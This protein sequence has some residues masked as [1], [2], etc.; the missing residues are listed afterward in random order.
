[1]SNSS[2]DTDPEYNDPILE[3]QGGRKRKIINKKKEK[4]KKRNILNSMYELTCNHIEKS[5]PTVCRVAELKEEDITEFK[6]N[7]CQI[8]DKVEQD[9]Y[10]LTFITVA[11][12]KRIDRKK[13]NR[14]P[15]IVANYFIPVIM[16]NMLKVCADSFSSITSIS[17]RR[18]NIINKKFMLTHSSP[19]EKRG[20]Y[21][22]NIIQ[23]EISHSIEEHIK[24]IKCRKSHHTRRDSGRSYLHPDLSITYMWTQ[25]KKKRIDNNKPI[26]SLSKYQTIFRSKFN[27]N[28]GH[29]RQDT[30]SYCSEQK[31][32][33]QLELDQDLKN[34]LKLQLTIHKRRAKK[35][36]ELL[37]EQS[38][39]SINCSFDMMQTQPIPKLS[40]TEVFYSRQVWI[41]NLTFVI[42]DINQG[43]DNCILYTWNETDSG[44]GPNEVCSALVNF[45]DL[46]ENKLKNESLPPTILNLFS[47]SCSGQNKN[48]FTMATLLFYINCKATIFTKINHIFPVRG[49]SYMPPDR[50]FGRIEQ[51]L[52]KKENIV[53]PKQYIDIFKQF[54][55]VKEYNKDFFIYNYKN[56]VKKIVKTKSQFKSTE[57]KIY[58]YIKGEETVGI[59]K[60]YG[61]LPEQVEVL[62]RK[63]KID[64]MFDLQ[65]LAQTNN[66]K[67]PKQADVKNLLKFFQI[68]DDAKQFYED[69]FKNTTDESII[70]EVPV[71][72][73]DDD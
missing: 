18:L 61:G 43:P 31:L 13:T 14:P 6:N 62:K 4:K 25:W 28:F 21:R 37:R 65:E 63:S 34:E 15:R 69:I 66:V 39:N 70:I 32:K 9:K 54:C 33:I 26:A 10:L 46:L 60:T 56:A 64:S 52:R 20:G 55:T 45:L 16:G 24:G 5:R 73:E 8:T 22:P 47:D 7:L 44:R 27:L 3:V 19:V 40:V 11:K 41:Y 29:P 72:D 68:P 51:V 57:Q 67:L 53:S 59:S 30:C 35:F 17:R 23:E 50:V 36:F 38:S 1:M 71:Y 48:Q 2:I 58:T 42:S 12:A 49:H